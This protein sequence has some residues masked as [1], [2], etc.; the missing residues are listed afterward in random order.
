MH[1]QQNIEFWNILFHVDTNVLSVDV[2][3]Y[4]ARIAHMLKKKIIGRC[5]QNNIY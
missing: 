5:K 1:G 2:I 4:T 3:K